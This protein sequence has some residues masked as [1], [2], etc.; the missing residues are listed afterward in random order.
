MT[1]DGSITDIP[2]ENYVAAEE[3]VVKELKELNKP[4]IIVLNTTDP[5]SPETINLAKELEKN[6]MY[7]LLF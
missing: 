3:R 7:L 6:T 2:R 1:T 5:Q 4:F